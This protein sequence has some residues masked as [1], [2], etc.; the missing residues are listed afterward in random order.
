MLRW[1]GVKGLH[2][3]LLIA[4]LSVYLS[5]MLKCSLGIWFM[6][7][8]LDKNVLSSFSMIYELSKECSFDGH[9]KRAFK[10]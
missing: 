10:H 9:S 5:L 6:E 8:L 1:V 7:Q 4:I 2:K 3:E